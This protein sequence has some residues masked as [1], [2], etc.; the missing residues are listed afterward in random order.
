MVHGREQKTASFE[1]KCLNLPFEIGLAR[2][3][4]F[5]R[6]FKSWQIHAFFHHLKNEMGVL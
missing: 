6:C 5:A 3:K 4:V 2:C 1:G